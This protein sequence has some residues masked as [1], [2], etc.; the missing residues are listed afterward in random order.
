MYQE[1]SYSRFQRSISYLLI[2]SIFFINSFQ[3]PLFEKTWAEEIK[4]IQLISVIVY[5]NV[6]SSIQSRI[7]RYAEDVQAKLNNTKVLIYKVP[8]DI[9]PQKIAALNERLFYE[10]DGTNNNSKLIGTVLVGDIPLPV[11]H[12]SSKTFLSVYPYIDFN[13]KNFIYNIDSG[14]Y[15]KAK[16]TPKDSNAEIWHSII[17]PNTWDENK[18][19]IKLIDFF[20]KDHDY[21][22]KSW[23]FSTSLQEPS[24]FYYD[25]KRD[26]SSASYSLRKWYE[27]YMKNI[28]D[29]SYNRFNKYLSKQIS[30]TFY[31][32]TNS[33]LTWALLSAGTDNPELKKYIEANLWAS[34]IDTKSVPDAM[35]KTIIEKLTKKFF[36]VF[37][38]KYIWD[39]LKYVYNTWRYGN[40][41][42]TRVDTI[43]SLV[44]KRDNWVKKILK[45]SNT[46]LEDYT[47]NILAKWGARNIAV[48]VR[49]EESKH[50]RYAVSS[51]IWWEEWWAPSALICNNSSTEWNW[52]STQ[53]YKSFEWNNYVWVLENYYNWLVGSDIKKAVDCS[54]YRWTRRTIDNKSVLVAATRA[55]NFNQD[56]IKA[57][58]ALLQS[59]PNA[60][61]CFAGWK[62]QTMAFWWG[63]SLFNMDTS[64]SWSNLKL[65]PTDY[66]RATKPI[67]DKAWW[68]AVGYNSSSDNQDITKDVANKDIET[69]STNS[70]LTYNW[71][72]TSPDNLSPG[73]NACNN[74]M[75]EHVAP[76]DYEPF[77]WDSFESIFNNTW[78]KVYFAKNSY[79]YHNKYLYLDNKQIKSNIWDSGG[80]DKYIINT[81]YY[82][83]KV[84]WVVEHKSP[85][86]EEFWAQLTNMATPSL[87]S[88]RNRYVDFVSARWN[89]TK[90]EYPN[91]Y[92]IRI[93]DTKN[94]NYNYVQSKVKEYLDTKSSDFNKILQA[95]NPTGLSWQDKAIYD[96]LKVTNTNYVTSV[97][98][99][100]LVTKDSKVLDEIVKNVL[101]VN[102]NST[103]L[104][105]KYVLEN[106]LDI[107]GNSESL[108]SGHKSDYEI[109]YMGSKWD[110]ANMYLW[111]DLSKPKEADRADKANNALARYN[112][113]KNIL[114][115]NKIGL[116]SNTSEFKCWP[117]EWV[118]I[119]Q[120]FSAIMCRLKTLVPPI[121]IQWWACGSKTLGVWSS[122]WMSTNFGWDFPTMS[123]PAF[124][125]D[126]DGNW[127]PDWAELIN[128]WNISLISDK[129]MY[130]YNK[131]VRLK[132]NLF[133]D[134]K[135]IGVD[136]SSVVSFNL[137]R[138]ISR[139]DKSPEVIFDASSDSY[140]SKKDI[141]AEYINFTPSQVRVNWWVA[142]YAFTSKWEDV[143]AVFRATISTKDKNGKVAVYKESNNLTTKVR[144][145]YLEVASIVNGSD[146]TTIKAW[147]T[148]SINFQ[149]KT[150]NKE[151]SQVTNEE[152]IYLN[153]YDYNSW[154]KIWDELTYNASNFNYSS[155]ILKKTGDYKFV[156]RDSIGIE[157]TENITVTN[158][159]VKEI[160][161]TPSSSQIVKWNVVD[162]LAELKDSFWNIPKWELYNITWVITWDWVFDS[163][164]EK[165]LK[166]SVLD[167]FYN[168]K[169]KSNWWAWNIQIKFVVDS[170][171][172]ESSILT[173]NVIDYAKTKLSIDDASNIIV[174]KEKHKINLQVVDGNNNLLSNFNWIAYFDFNQLNWVIS[175]NFVKIEHWKPTEDIFIIPNFVASK[176]LI[177]NTT[178]PWID[179]VEWNKLT[180]LPDKPMYVWLQNTKS[181][182]EAK[183]WNKATLKAALYDRY[184]NIVF[185][186][187]SH[188]INFYI[189]DEYKKYVNLGWDVYSSNK[190]VNEWAT[191][192]DAYTTNIPGSSY[193]LAEATPALENNSITIKWE[194]N[195]VLTAS[196]VSENAVLFNSYYLFNKEKLD[197]INYNSL[198]TVLEWA[199]YWDIT[200][201]WYLAW[202][203]LFNKW[204]RSLWVS[205]II[206][207]PV[208][209][210]TA[211]WFT[212]GGKFIA[213]TSASKDDTFSLEPEINSNSNWTAINLYDGVYKELIARAW[214][215]FDSNTEL[216]D[217][218]I[219]AS[220]D[221][222]K[223]RI[224]TDSSYIM[225]KW[226]NWLTTRKDSSNMSLY[227]NNFKIFDIDNL[228]RIN[229]DPW[230]TIKL[231]ENSDWNMLGMK[232]ILN[233]EE[234]WYLWMKF[235]TD[236]INVFDSSDFPNI[237]YDHKGQIVIEKI[238]SE[239][240]FDT[241]FL[242]ISSHWAKWIEFYRNMDNEEGG[243]D[244][245]LVSF[246]DKLWL[247][248]YNEQAWIGWEWK[249]KMLLEFAGWNSLWDSTK[250]YQTYSF[251]NLWDPVISLETKAQP[252]SDFNRTIG[253]KLTEEKW[254][255]MESYKKID[256]NWDKNDDIVVF[257]EDWHIEL[258]AN[259]NG[260][261][262][263]MWYLAYIADAWKLRKWV[264]DFAW[265]WFDDIVFVN[266]SWQLWVLDNIKAKFA[267]QYP[268]ILNEAAN[269]E[270]FMAWQIEQLEVF[271]M[272]KDWLDDIITVDDSWDLS[273]LY[274]A[275][276]DSKYP[277][278]LIFHKKIIDST[279]WLK[280]KST[281]VKTWGA[282]YYDSLPQIP[283]MTSQSQ[284][285][286]QSQELKDNLA[287]WTN[288]TDNTTL[289]AMLNRLVYYQERYQEYSNSWV[290]VSERQQIIESA[291]GTDE[292]WNPNTALAN[293]LINSQ[294]DLVISNWSW[295]TN[296]SSI[297]TS[298]LEKTKTFIRS[299]YWQAY[300]VDITKSYK[301]V[302]SWRL[303]AWDLV[304]V[305]LRLT[306][307]SSKKLNNIL[308][309][310]S[311]K[312]FI[313]NWDN[314]TYTIHTN[315]ISETRML[316][317]K[318]DWEFDYSFDNFSL[319][320]WERA[321]IVYN[322]VMPN[323]SFGLITVG[324]LEKNDSYWDVALNP[325][326]W[327]WDD[328][329]IW[330][331]IAAK[332]YKKWK[333]TFADKSKLPD[334]IE[335]NKVD[336]DDNGIPDYIDELNWNPTWSGAQNYAKDQLSDY[337]K[338]AN[339]NWIPDKDEE[340]G[341]GV[342]SYNWAS[343]DVETT[344]LNIANLDTINSTIDTVVNWLGCWF[345]WWGCI[346]MPLN[347]APLA[348]WG[349]PTLFG[350]PVWDW[351]KVWEWLPSF[352]FPTF[353]PVPPFVGTWPPCPYW[354]WWR[355]DGN[356]FWIWLSQ[357][358]IFITP[359][360]TG[361]A[362][363]A[364]CFGSNNWVWWTP[365]PWLS[366]LI[367]WWGCVVAAV[368]LF[369]CSNNWSDWDIGSQ[370][371][372]WY[373]N[374]NKFF[375]AS[376]C[377]KTTSW[378]GVSQETNSQI[379]QYLQ[380]NTSLA[381]IILSDTA[382]Q[383]WSL[384]TDGEPIIWLGSSWGSGDSWD[385]LDISI[386]SSAIK[387][388]DIDNIVKIDFKRV[389][390]FP[391]FIMDWVTRQIEEIVNK[392]VTLP[393]LKIILPDFSWIADSGWFN[394]WEKYKDTKNKLADKEKAENAK[395]EAENAKN[396]QK[397]PIVQNETLNN[398]QQKFDEQKA[399]IQNSQVVQKT[400]E[401][402]SWVK[403]AYEVVSNLP[404]IKLESEQININIPRIWPEEI[405]K[406]IINA[407]GKVKK[408]KTTIKETTESWSGFTNNPAA[409][410]SFKVLLDA[411]KLVKSV[412]K[413]IKILKEYKKFP[414]K[415]RKYITW[416]EMYLSQ[417]LCNLEIINKVTGWRIKDNGKRFKTWVELIVLLKAI[418]KSW[419][420]IIDVFAEFND[421]C[422]V[423]HNERYDLK[424]FITKLVSMLIPKL[425]IIIFPKWPDI[426]IDLH[427]IRAWLNIAMPEF[428]FKVKPIVLP[429]LPDLTLPDTPSLNIG[430]K[431]SLP[432]IWTLPE[433]PELPDLPELP[434][435]PSVKLP[436]LPP[437]PTIPKMFGIIEM[438]LNLVKL[439]SKVIC[440]RNKIGNILPPEWRAWD[441]IAW[442]TERN[443]TMPLDKL[444]IDLP[445]FS[446]SF[447]D[448]IKVTSYVN[449]EF[450]AAFIIEMAKS[451][452]EPFNK[453]SND[454]S[455]INKW[456]K[457]PTLDFKW[458]IPKID[459]ID[460]NLKPWIP[461]TWAYNNNSEKLEWYLGTIVWITAGSILNTVKTM[462]DSNW[463]K[464]D[465]ATFKNDLK[466][467]LTPLAISNNPKEKQIYS[468]LS[469]AID[470]KW[471]S[472]DKFIDWLNKSNDDKF[473]D[474]K[475]LIKEYQ[476]E[477]DA[478]N[479]ELQQ[480]ENWD[481]SI[482]DFSPIKNSFWWL[483]VVWEY[484]KDNKKEFTNKLSKQ[485]DKFLASVS[486][487][488]GYNTDPNVIAMKKTWD[489][490]TTKI[491][492]QVSK[493]SQTLLD[494]IPEKT[495]SWYIA[496]NYA[497]T[498]TDKSNSGLDYAYNY[499]W[500]Y[501]TNK[502]NKQ[503][504]LFDYLDEID[505]KS[506]VVEFDAD[507]DGDN[508]V[509]YEMWWALYYKENLSKKANKNHIS[510]V[511]WI[512]DIW[513]INSFLDV[514]SSATVMPFAPNY[515][516]ET[517]PTANSINFK[518]A[519]ANRDAE[520]S[521]R[522]EF[523]DYIE[524]FDATNNV[525][526]ANKWLSPFARLNLVDMVT[527]S[528]EDNI[529][530]TRDG[531][532]IKNNFAT[533]DAGI[534]SINA[535]VPEYKILTSWN[536]LSI[537]SWKTIY[538][539][540]DWLTIK[541]R[542]DPN[543]NYQIVRIQTKSN[544]EFQSNAD[545]TILDWSMI[546]TYNSTTDY[547]WDISVL[548]WI[549]VLPWFEMNFNNNN[550]YVNI[551]YNWWGLL[552]VDNWA[553]Y[554]MISL[555]SQTEM[556][557]VNMETPNEFYYGKLYAFNNS[558]RTNI[559]D[560]TLF[561]PQ[562]EA[563]NEAPLVALD[564]GI[565]LPVYKQKIINLKKYITDISWIKEI[566]IDADITKDSD[567]DW[568]LD[569]DKDS[570][571]TNTKYGIKK[572]STIYDIV[573]WP[574][575]EL[576]NK[577]VML[578]TIDYNNN[579]SA[580]LVDFE[581]Y[582]PIPEI[583]SVAKESSL[584]K[585]I[586]NEN[587]SQEP[588]DIFRY[589]D[590]VLSKIDTKDKTN[591]N[592]DD[593]GQFN[594]T[595]A[596]TAQGLIITKK[597]TSSWATNT[598]TIAIINEQTWKIDI[599]DIGYWLRVKWASE[600]IK[601][602][603]EIYN[604]TTSVKVYEQSFNLSSNQT[605][606]Q[607]S[608][609][610]K[611][612]KWIF[613][614]SN[615]DWFALAKNSSN[616]PYL[617]NWA[618]ITDSNYNWIAWVWSD[619]NI[620]LLN[621]SY[622][623]SYDNFSDFVVIKIINSSWEA[624]WS[625]MYKINAFYILK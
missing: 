87:P 605:I 210:E 511:E 568:I 18:D 138:L 270:V 571:D 373:N 299:Q 199:N 144:W 561:S 67:Y 623:L 565:K 242:W 450:D 246:W 212:P 577:K 497:T 145:Y 394:F 484:S 416:K 355:F 579:K 92:R 408:Y 602:T 303:Q 279:L 491:N 275:P 452:L 7:N 384:W 8:A 249:N 61:T 256:F 35:T 325:T 378:T 455:N 345:W 519:S 268:V 516:E 422:A 260:N 42:N 492:E 549:P 505:P 127:I 9:T 112:Q 149:I 209:R 205:S 488:N 535:K 278:K 578:Y 530:E 506:S 58:T 170:E 434:S 47:D 289:S 187:F 443:W 374:G 50:Y 428:S 465:I 167:W 15:E 369:G 381:K 208:G 236:S 176:N 80:C 305:T 393:T 354:A 600:N 188:T 421:N 282:I 158:A 84:L 251:V 232:L 235:R 267:R 389:S 253:K 584:I 547:S 219:W 454:L 459:D 133:Y 507:G 586:I 570:L 173:I 118:P 194:N 453:F 438:M 317:E 555:G 128:K 62:P 82:F 415:F 45:D 277:G 160:K 472:E 473:S 229:K 370:W 482:K 281:P 217:C 154:E 550:S 81:S 464:S 431:L 388:L 323:V 136:D 312:N 274:W 283:D 48:P 512:R 23:V 55:D 406:W 432:S 79:D 532:T 414:S 157:A 320:P 439:I 341:N 105:Y 221:I 429:Q 558:K 162:I 147:S 89:Q 181:K 197:N 521:F 543:S 604:R 202:E 296:I 135:L 255:V 522:L 130:S 134:N 426:I 621:N 417:I 292:N 224:P 22:T 599:K 552:T 76:Y 237:L 624:V 28:E 405:D 51:G 524:R 542:F 486:K 557:Y 266:K 536:S 31:S 564:D 139:K 585:W 234:I 153:I 163:N 231:D 17:A 597:S 477:N 172:A 463:E 531:L 142:N 297:N 39:I 385:S 88:D 583:K 239:Y 527:S 407:E 240:Y 164:S 177:I 20:D 189:P 329:I 314:S 589:R 104:K 411:D 214:L 200:H 175:P 588:I 5:D 311:N 287:S 25:G 233:K 152:P 352:S 601:S 247:E 326:S 523:Y 74:K 591:D 248:Q 391:D 91:L 409:A 198:Y 410:A 241:T 470:Y 294:N 349:D 603:I 16:E 94:L 437:P 496:P 598:W 461:K 551:W 285:I 14:F 69:S 56:K 257:Y 580:T 451:T 148:D 350:F 610:D 444:F 295:L 382:V 494:T 372:L 619:G 533:I 368:P 184:S 141:I 540:N 150:F 101:W 155:A 195:E 3:I 404:L 332:E 466:N 592:T 534:G 515:F 609:F 215:N 595:G 364:I 328:Q 435:L 573:V 174:G 166:V 334:A 342:F 222:S 85:T 366:P 132:A 401:W 316:N 449:L 75:S 65:W 123:N 541:Y 441:S 614:V 546:L 400:K 495:G 529:I 63:Y 98:F 336:E 228:G 11:I 99:Y 116:S 203:M 298:V 392:L 457:I 244:K 363:T 423:C 90:F 447:I 252:G 367:P 95:E 54:M 615:K 301:D 485:E 608:D 68:Q 481:K 119:F 190:T 562:T 513:D 517:L 24:V 310:D 375:N 113:I 284:Y 340:W 396:E 43:I 430:I 159:W 49:I 359:T 539:W 386:D 335:K 319:N 362:W 196:W 109:A 72:Y 460:L 77:S 171:Q 276:S 581:V 313:K 397:A 140:E 618:Y 480:I 322:L 115:A 204:S 243:V 262:K 13:E 223:C 306:N 216:V 503:T 346:S 245:D 433:L 436:D 207:N 587:I 114:S 554:R 308:Y 59:S 379:I 4:N 413:N 273:I 403:S 300:W 73:K 544:I 528:A 60:Q 180:I 64:W 111:I 290:T 383:H 227:L 46:V 321:E 44:S 418:L 122:D 103:V 625:L 504:R 225:L 6:Y 186:D 315:S 110:A 339:N 365:P 165:T 263:N 427:N 617:A 185:N 508:D 518:F 52:Y 96:E 121:A 469:K 1:S 264:W 29:I 117:A 347:W 612:D 338:D 479:K 402:I 41:N 553:N 107:D 514:S 26:E 120:W 487:L 620:Y 560:L 483:K 376:S 182:L 458:A 575:N 83:K 424:H 520:K 269:Q 358:R 351:L 254:S 380:W 448:A 33:E 606:Q 183:T 38:E 590:G 548:R 271:D 302:N 126:K 582:A 93:L 574:Y 468:E 32:A 179:D 593:T 474:L 467:S 377:T 412:E 499:E 594:I 36:Q 420:L 572:W 493:Y 490:I 191:S 30:D 616:I 169:L 361:S 344:W 357:F 78:W 40:T 261:L 337:N 445:N 156:I 286:L 333:R 489:E 419:Q 206:N 258:L 108:D 168:F 19:K 569:N 307:N 343:W 567:W 143:D 360:I 34:W 265:D 2:F 545:V 611:V 291:V 213:N 330:A 146:T 288:N 566:Y 622:S 613:F 10:W 510:G 125:E 151:N 12:D 250:F 102:L 220:N 596:S 37:N 456:T 178:V 106:Y 537:Q 446:V 440:L 226:Y 124:L 502:D 66:R 71:M 559:T 353:C 526:W 476:K 97:D 238:S 475:N 576:M 131:T 425:P 478:M 318:I 27:L 53:E 398:V 280:L 218:G 137:V 399:N 327:C 100:W 324:L 293:E 161:L 387:N 192:I 259:Y 201:P 70:C 371:I 21:Y 500:I 348:P 304:E 471:N 525:R 356:P 498:N 395:K 509:I 331:S 607:V 57:D 556:Y 211:F 129:T 442:L 272:N 538:A 193:I 501:V 462:K 309:Y 86:D 390:S 230:I 563:D